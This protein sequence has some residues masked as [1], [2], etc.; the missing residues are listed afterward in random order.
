MK[1]ALTSIV[2]ALGARLREWVRPEHPWD[3]EAELFGMERKGKH[4][5]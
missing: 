4:D 1:A 5:G 2:R 3:L